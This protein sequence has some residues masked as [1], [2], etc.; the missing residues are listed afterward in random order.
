MKAFNLAVLALLSTL[1]VGISR[2]SL[3]ETEAQCVAKYGSES[4]VEVGL[5]YDVV[6]DRAVTY[7]VKTASGSLNLRVTFLQGTVAHEEISSLDP[8]RPLSEEKLKALLDSESAGLKWRK[9]NSVFRTDNSGSTYGTENWSRSDGATAKFWVTGKA[10]SRALSGQMEL[11]TK[12]FTDAQAFF[13]KQDG[14]N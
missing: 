10:G 4:D 3:G 11:S 8:A 12:K 1:G 14:A 5:G 6:G 9:G 2:A 13:D 7:Q